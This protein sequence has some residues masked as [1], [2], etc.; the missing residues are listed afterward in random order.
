MGKCCGRGHN[1]RG[2]IVSLMW[3]DESAETEEGKAD[4]DHD[5]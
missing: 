4:E 5:Q 3:L 1:L 2:Q